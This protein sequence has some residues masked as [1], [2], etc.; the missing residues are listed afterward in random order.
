L[1]IEMRAAHERTRGTCGS[2][3]LQKDLA[4]YGVKVGSSR[5]RRIRKKLGIHC[6]QAKKFKV[7]TDSKHTLPVAENLLEQNFE[8][9]LPNRVW[10]SDITHIATDEG[11]LYCA[12]HKDLFN[13]EIVGYALTERITKDIV[14]QSLLAAVKRRQ[15]NPGLIR[16]GQVP[17]DNLRLVLSGSPFRF[18][19]HPLSL[20]GCSNRP[21][22]G[23][24]P[25]D[26]GEAAAGCIDQKTL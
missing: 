1:E 7:T 23:F 20:P 8:V 16:D 15:P 12:A 26:P 25:E 4:E 3:R 14:I 21:R 13:G 6:K 18:I 10:V 22:Q 2:E 5:I 17:S 9:S 24:C 11:W 19:P